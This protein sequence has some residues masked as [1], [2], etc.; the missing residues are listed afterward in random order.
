[1]NPAVNVVVVTH[2]TIDRVQNPEEC[3]Y[4]TEQYF[5]SYETMQ[6]DPWGEASKFYTSIGKE[7]VDTFKD[8]Y[9]LG[10]LCGQVTTTALLFSL[11]NGNKAP[12][13]EVCKT[14]RVGRWMSQAECNKMIETGT[15]QFSTNGNTT[16]VSNPANIDAYISAPYKHKSVYVEFDVATSA[17]YP[18]SK[19]TWSQIPGPGSNAAKYNEILGGP[20]IE[21]VVTAENIQVVGR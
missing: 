20:R 17:L 12:T 9:R 19:S 21:G 5:D 2:S 14:T 3:E 16:Y 4:L 11:G 8:P 1:L 15:V 7:V 6:A 13:A 10:N 18:A